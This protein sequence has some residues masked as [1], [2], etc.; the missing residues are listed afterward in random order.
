MPLCLFSLLVSINPSNPNK[1]FSRTAFDSVSFK[2]NENSG[3]LVLCLHG[4][5]GYNCVATCLRWSYSDFES[6]RSHGIKCCS[7]CCKWIHTISGQCTRN[8]DG[9]FKQMLHLAVHNVSNHRTRHATLSILFWQVI[10][11]SAA[12]LLPRCI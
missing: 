11:Q 12:D 4:E 6:G 7:R 1:C 5:Q 3:E 9:S 8:L 10:Y 2:S